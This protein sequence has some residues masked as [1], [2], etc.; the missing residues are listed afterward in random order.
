MRNLAD[1]LSVVLDKYTPPSGVRISWPIEYLWKRGVLDPAQY[2]AANAFRSDYECAVGQSSA[3]IVNWSAFEAMALTDN[4]DF[5]GGRHKSAMRLARVPAGPRPIVDA[6]KNLMDLR[7][8]IGG[9]SFQV[10]RGVCGLGIPLVALATEIKIDK[11][12]VSVVLRQALWESVDFYG[13]EEN[14]DAR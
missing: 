11:N 10:M 2:A 14:P 12:T 1:T 13:L 8:A 4:P 5:L 7:W 6:K 9:F 3:P